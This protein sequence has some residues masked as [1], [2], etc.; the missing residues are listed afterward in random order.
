[1]EDALFKTLII[2]FSSIGDIALSS[3]LVRTLHQRFPSARIDFVIKSEFAELVAHNP[4]LTQVY[5]LP[6]GGTFGDLHRLR[7]TI[8]PSSYDLI[9]DI[10]DSLRSRFLS[11]GAQRVVRINKRKLARFLLVHT[12][13]DT[14]RFWGGAPSVALRYLEPVQHLDVKDDG[15]GLEIHLPAEARLRAATIVQQVGIV[16]ADRVLAVCPGAKH[17]NKIWLAE[18]FAEVATRASREAGAALVLLGGRDD[19][20]RCAE[21]ETAIRRS[22]PHATVTNLAGSLSLL[23][24]AAVMERCTAVVTNDSGL[25]HLAAC[26]KRS[27]VAVFGPTV[28]Q[29]GFFPFGTENSVVEHPHLSCR[30]CTH[31]GLPQCPRKHFRCMEEIGA[32]QVYE[33]VRR[34]L[35][36]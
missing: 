22:A 26:C 17:G 18:R 8:K 29:F 25:M 24:T 31:I 7:S 11:I 20:E 4:Y 34:F 15:N 21:I 2:R 16:P 6:V 28:R 13:W 33:N 9:I 14:Y 12:S 5:A 10:H 27:V 1:M 19:A 35:V 3:L 36:H 23:E 30:P 32:D